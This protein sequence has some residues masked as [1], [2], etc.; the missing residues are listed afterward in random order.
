ME[1]KEYTVLLEYLSLEAANHQNLAVL[2]SMHTGDLPRQLW[3]DL[4]KFFMS[5]LKRAEI[6]SL[7]PSLKNPR[8]Y[9]H[10]PTEVC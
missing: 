6:G 4:N 3:F 7:Q 5:E 2:D 1:Q 10:E 9:G 8:I